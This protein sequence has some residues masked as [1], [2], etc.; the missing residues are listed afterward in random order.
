MILHFYFARRFS[1]AFLCLTA[2]FYVF[3][4]LVDLIEQTRKFSRFDI[5]FE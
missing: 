3:V 4:I 2:V 1:V 5:F